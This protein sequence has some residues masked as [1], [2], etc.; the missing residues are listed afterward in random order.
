MERKDA[1]RLAA[2]SGWAAAAGIGLAV[3]A[4]NGV[5]LADTTGTASTSAGGPTASVSANSTSKAGAHRESRSRPAHPGRTSESDVST[6]RS[7]HRAD[8]ASVSGDDDTAAPPRHPIVRQLIANAGA[9]L[10]SPRLTDPAEPAPLRH[11]PVLEMVFAGLRRADNGAPTPGPQSGNLLA[12]SGAESGDPSLSGYASV[13]IPGWT[14]T[15]TP[16]VVQYGTLRRMPGL[17]GTKGPTLLPYFGFPS[18]TSAPADSGVQFFGGGNVATSTL[19]QT[20][21]LTAAQSAVDTGALTFVLSGA[22]GGNLLDGS[23]AAVTVNFYDVDNVYLGNASIG[24][25]TPWDRRFK[26][27]LQQRQTAG[28][29]PVG[30]DSAQIVVTLT[31][32][33]P[34]LGNYNNAYADD[35]SFT[36]GTALSA[37]A[38]PEPPA[39][40]VGSLDH[41]VMVYMENHGVGDIVGSPNAPYINSLINT[42]GNATNYY[43]LTHPSDPNYWP[44][45]GGSDFGVNYNCSS[46]CFDAPNLAAEIIAA[47]KNWAAYQYGG[48]GYSEPNDRTPFLAFHD[49]F[50]NPD[51]VNSH[52][53]DISKMAADFNGDDPSQVADFV[54]FS[55]DEDTNM[56]GPIDSLVGIVRFALSQLTDHQYNVKAGDEFIKEQMSVIFDS[57]L[58]KSNEST[59]VFLTFDEDYNNISFGIGNE[60]NHVVMVVIPNQAAIDA[61]M[62]GGA[63][64]ADDYY[65]HYSL[66]R[67]IEDSLDLDPLTKNDEYAQPL[68]EFWT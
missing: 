65:N 38:A 67:T 41:V 43:A 60:G 57:A 32:R 51:L 31:D 11:T 45:L 42:Y 37:P 34:I 18:A 29:V 30:T 55:A 19:T 58:W 17:F 36:V 21:H 16:T 52:I 48:G 9:K 53:F 47:G 24:P 61:G 63:F 56:E 54:W 46:D 44:I 23:A 39:S 8:R 5:A 27:E 7:L 15:G 3:A 50:T 6:A 64:S 66:Q 40:N 26:T 4:G 59:A 68:N 25:V 1:G 62:R 2:L 28:F 10:R 13:T 49:I 12:N 20:V 22:L 35:L 14:V 33:N